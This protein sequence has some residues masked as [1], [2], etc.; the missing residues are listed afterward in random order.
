MHYV[1]QKPYQHYVLYN[2]Q[3]SYCFL[4]VFNSFVIVWGGFPTD[5]FFLKLV[6]LPRPLLTISV[7]PFA[8]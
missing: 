2:A 4:H 7:N 3:K 1:V 8:V 6:N 5:F